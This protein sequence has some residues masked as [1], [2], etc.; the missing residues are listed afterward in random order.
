M[1]Q[2]HNCILILSLSYGFEM[3]IE[4]A[5]CPDFCTQDSSSHRWS[6]PPGWGDVLLKLLARRTKNTPGTSVFRTKKL[7]FK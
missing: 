7:F 3:N 1:F 4:L 6:V 2:N 5:T